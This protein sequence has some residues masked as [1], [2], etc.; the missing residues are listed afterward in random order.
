MHVA[1]CRF[2]VYLCL[3]SHNLGFDASTSGQSTK[4]KKRK[5]IAFISFQ[6]DVMNQPGSRSLVFKK[7]VYAD[8]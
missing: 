3:S 7:A 6:I 2:N 5:I 4:T 1:K 8:S